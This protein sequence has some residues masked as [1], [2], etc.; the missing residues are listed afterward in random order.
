MKFGPLEVIA[1]G[2]DEPEFTGRI[3]PELEALRKTG[4]VRLIDMVVVRKNTMGDVKII[5][6]SDLEFEE[7]ELYRPF[8]DDFLSMFTEDDLLLLGRSLE[9]DSAAAL[10]LF[11]HTWAIKLKESVVEA[12]GFLLAQNRVPQQAL[13]DLEELSEEE[14]SAVEQVG[15]DDI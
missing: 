8:L 12:G 11:E 6:A 4:V 5:E 15:Q 1:I 14:L 10:V 7:S 2:F 3:M 9:K 13:K